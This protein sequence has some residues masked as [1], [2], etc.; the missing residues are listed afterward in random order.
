MDQTAAEEA[1]PAVAVSRRGL[2]LTAALM[3]TFMPAVE[4]TIVA[5]AM[6]T[7]VSDLGGFS[8]FS[9]VF[10][11]Y[12][13]AMA[14]TVPVYGRLADIYGRRIVFFAGTGI[15]LAGT[16]LCGFAGSMTALILF[17]ALQG[18]GAGA[19][20]P[21]ASTI[22]GDIYTP[23]E[24]ARVQGYVSSVFGVSAI[25]G[26]LLGAF[27]VEHLHW[28]LVFWVNLPV[29]AASIAMFAR[30]LREPPG[31]REHRIDWLGAALLTVG[32][33]AAM[34]AL[35]QARGLGAGGVAAVAALAV[36]T[37]ALL[38][39]HERRVPEP[40]VPFRLWRSRVI[41]AA[42]LGTFGTGAAM[43]GVSAFLPAYVQGVMG[44][45]PAVAGFALG[46]QSVSWTLATFL[47][48]RL[49][50]HGSYRLSA[51]SGA[52]ALLIGGSMLSLLTPQS[53]IALA[54]G[55]SLVMGIGMGLCNPAF[56]VSI[57]ASVGWGQR[58]AA[59]G[60]NMFMR[61]LGQ[62]TGAALFGAIVNFGVHA[63][64][65]DAGDAVNRL[66]DPEL[67][68]AL[69]A[70]EE[71]RLTEAFA[72]AV[73]NVYLVVIAVAAATLAVALAFPAGLGPRS[74]R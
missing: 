41:A 64:L 2:V 65:P 40:I 4:S 49:M 67:R 28:S 38:A 16:T 63:R 59:T 50:I 60:G 17:R 70:A 25:A 30:Y 46:C 26:P 11:V 73:H 37:L 57:Q 31:R 66:L 23:T 34:L 42:N 18:L 24:R 8:L 15:F 27:I 33:G 10:A 48:A 52:L 74:G 29:G 9:W 43:M 13:L 61:M 5:T 45:A 68:V 47:A 22:V 44:R 54:A 35:V 58:G 69:G 1:R 72:A 36:A 56:L 20:Q 12:L 71:A 21:I 6:P 3:A 62:S 19:I 39:A 51:A 55:G 14:V 32:V 53:S 7:I